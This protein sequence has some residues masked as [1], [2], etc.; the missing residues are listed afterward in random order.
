M[1][2]HPL[3]KNMMELSVKS[4]ILLLDLQ[5]FHVVVEMDLQKNERAV[6][7]YTSD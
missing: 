4:R 7:I 1:C 3:G 5:T 2:S 6:K